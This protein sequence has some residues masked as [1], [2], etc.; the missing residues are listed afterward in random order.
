MTLTFDSK[1]KALQQI[2]VQTWLDKPDNAVTLK[3]TMN[4]L[5][6]GVSHPAA[7]VLGMPKSQIEVRITKSNYQKLAQ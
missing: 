3:V 2:D 1:V 5:P 4:A 7:V 6:D